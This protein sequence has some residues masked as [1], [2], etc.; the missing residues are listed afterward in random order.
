MKVI[1]I[2]CLRY[3]EGAVCVMLLLM[4]L[5]ELCVCYAISH[6]VDGA[7]CYAITHGVEGAVCVLCYYSWC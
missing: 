6:G 7:V 5:R 1:K 3:V 4:V 2:K